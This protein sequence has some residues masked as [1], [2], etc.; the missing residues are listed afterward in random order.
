M[1]ARKG[2]APK[3][4][5]AQRREPLSIKVEELQVL[6]IAARAVE[7]ATSFARVYAKQSS[8]VVLGKDGKPED[9]NELAGCFARDAARKAAQLVEIAA[10]LGLVVVR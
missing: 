1:A 7:R 2:K 3:K 4:T 6:A 10:R 5:A 9:V 8:G